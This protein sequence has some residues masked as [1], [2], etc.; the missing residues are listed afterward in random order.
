MRSGS[1]SQGWKEIFNK[2]YRS[3]NAIITCNLNTVLLFHS[4]KRPCKNIVY[5]SSETIKHY[6]TDLRQH[7]AWREDLH[8]YSFMLSLAVWKQQTEERKTD[9]RSSHLPTTHT[10]KTITVSYVSVINVVLFLLRGWVRKRDNNNTMLHYLLQ[11][12]RWSN[13]YDR[14]DHQLSQ[15]R[16][17]KRIFLNSI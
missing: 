17:V 8:W 3:D 14:L 12:F 4:V 9:G 13:I 2:M 16:T 7:W 6:C 11:L 1:L 10:T 5:P 15:I